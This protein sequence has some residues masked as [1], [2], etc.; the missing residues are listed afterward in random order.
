[1]SRTDS[2]TPLWLVVSHDAGGAEIVSSWV[3]AHPENRFIFILEG[4]AVKIFEQK[5]GEIENFSA[6]ELNKLTVSVD[7][8][9]TGTSWASDLEKK[10][11]LLA[12]TRGTRVASYIDRWDNYPERF[13]LNGEQILPDEIWVGDNEGLQLAN[14]HFPGKNIRLEPNL[15][16]QEILNEIGS[17]GHPDFRH[18]EIRVLYV[19]EPIKDHAKRQYGDE[20]Y[21]GYNE[22]DA[23]RY[24][25]RK[26]KLVEGAKGN[27]VIRVR[28]HPSERRDKYDEILE[29]SDGY[30][31]H[32]SFE[33][34]LVEDCVW[35]DRVVGCQN[36][37]MVVSLLAGREVY[38]SI[39]PGGEK[40]GLPHREIK[41]MA[42]LTI[43]K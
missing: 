33:S 5:M 24:F 8:V 32:L 22:Y 11:V 42:E 29:S 2:K 19:C 27:I 1:M 17:K 16:L 35:A 20:D 18:D 9:L 23:M 6:Q 13:I 15:Y 39:P 7:H 37:A 43:S 10:A 28:L 30:G 34:S 36:M 4:P 3:R 38:C 21:W 31:V 25:F 40:C 12:K 14:A 26:I 41:T